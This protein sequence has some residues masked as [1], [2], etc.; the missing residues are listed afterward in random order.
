MRSI[1]SQKR[2]GVRSSAISQNTLGSLEVN[3]SMRS[4][5]GRELSSDCSIP[6]RRVTFSNYVSENSATD[7]RSQISGTAIDNDPREAAWLE[8]SYACL[9]DGE[10]DFSLQTDL[11]CLFSSMIFDDSRSSFCSLTAPSDSE[12]SKKSALPLASNCNEYIFYV[13]PSYSND[14]S[15]DLQSLPKIY[16]ID[17]SPESDGSVIGNHYRDNKDIGEIHELQTRSDENICERVDIVGKIN[18]LQTVG[19][20]EKISEQVD[21][22]RKINELETVKSDEQIF[23]RVTADGKRKELQAAR[24][25]EKIF[26]R[27]DRNG[28]QNE[29]RAV[30][31]DGKISER[32]N[33]NGKICELPMVRDD[34]RISKGV[35]PDAKMFPQINTDPKHRRSIECITIRL[36]DVS[37]TV[38][39]VSIGGS[40]SVEQR[41][42]EYFAK[43]NASTDTRDLVVLDLAGSLTNHA[44]GAKKGVDEIFDFLR[45]PNQSHDYRDG[46]ILGKLKE[47]RMVRSDEKMSERV[48]PDAKMCREINTDRAY[49]R[50]TFDFLQQTGD[51]IDTAFFLKELSRVSAQAFGNHVADAAIGNIRTIEETDFVQ[52]RRKSDNVDLLRIDAETYGE[53]E[54]VLIEVENLA[55]C[56]QEIDIPKKSSSSRLRD[57]LREP[58]ESLIGNLPEIGKSSELVASSASNFHNDYANCSGINKCCLIC[59]RK[60]TDNPRYLKKRQI[61]LIFW[62]VSCEETRQTFFVGHRFKTIFNVF[63]LTGRELTTY[64]IRNKWSSHS[65]RIAVEFLVSNSY[66]HTY[67]CT[68]FINMIFRCL[69]IL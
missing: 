38:K 24:S 17:D 54:T 4:S 29:S 5:V 39:E 31:G 26:K 22:D 55:D 40:D 37:S 21:T 12:K 52:A 11:S 30:R 66:T 6:K 9:T 16:A 43:H 2:L 8:E 35:V 13:N 18:E 56:F 67:I 50:N 3:K 68:F 7:T 46:K 62:N 32:A 47:L 65:G 44:N 48:V 57:C 45:R 27:F 53:F 60:K 25:D 34:E 19:S 42:Y 28:K 51:R 64:F 49:E 61:H 63:F 58:C 69:E 41:D 20:D 23:E 59:G 15:C 36:K 10:D 14:S 33:T 1:R